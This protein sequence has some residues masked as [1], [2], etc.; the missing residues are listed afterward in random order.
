[1]T[2]SPPRRGYDSLRPGT[3]RPR[4]RARD[5]PARSSCRFLHPSVS[6]SRLRSSVTGSP[7]RRGYGSRRPGTGRPHSQSRGSPARSSCRFLH[8]S[9]SRSRL[10]SWVTDSLSR[11][12][13][14]SLPPGTGRPRSRARDSPARSSC[15]FLHPSARSI[16]PRSW[17]TDSLSHSAQRIW[18]SS[19]WHWP[20]P[21]VEPGQSGATVQCRFLDIPS[22]SQIG[23]ISPVPR[24]SATGSPSHSARNPH[25]P[26][27]GRP[28]RWPHSPA[29][30][31]IRSRHTLDHRDR[32][33]P[34]HYTPNRSR[35]RNSATGS[36]SHSARNPHPPG[37]DRPR[38]WPHS[39]ADRSIRS[40]HTLDHR[41]RPDPGHYTPNRSRPR[42]P[43]LT[44]IRRRAVHLTARETLPAIRLRTA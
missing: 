43:S 25:P 19:A 21:Q 17:V 29:D 39:P 9:A 8:P 12:G 27:T 37:T 22:G 1:M 41:D 16:R 38:R 42:I 28:R 15:R 20:S 7:P 34:G 40:R 13:Y 32:P 3:G 26:G 10:R 18:L 6:R 31:S 14:G 4:S 23:R 33:D 36:P 11:R 44:A 24:N 30:R 35:P 5:S 2:G